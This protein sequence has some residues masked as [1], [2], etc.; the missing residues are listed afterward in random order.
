[1]TPVFSGRTKL[2]ISLAKYGF[3]PLFKASWG[4]RHIFFK[5]NTRHIATTSGRRGNEIVFV[6]NLVELGGGERKQNFLLLRLRVTSVF[7]SFFNLQTQELKMHI[8]ASCCAPCAP[9]KTRHG[10]LR[11]IRPLSAF[12]SPILCGKAK[13][14]HKQ[15]SERARSA[16]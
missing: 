8:F 1:M 3:A 15:C 4:E 9:T 5:C 6:K 7:A 16:V 10:V 12:S 14:R 13:N 11:G 2:A